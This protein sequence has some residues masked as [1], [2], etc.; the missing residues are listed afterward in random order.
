MFTVT[1]FTH[2]TMV[3][4]IRQAIRFA[5]MGQG[6]KMGGHAHRC[7]VPNGKGHNFLRVDYRNKEVTILSGCTAANGSRG[8]A[9]DVTALVKAALTTI[10]TAINPNMAVCLDN[11]IACPVRMVPVQ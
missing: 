7:Y 9:R 2:P 3:A 10:Q 11:E 4:K 5:V 1:S 6:E 8:R